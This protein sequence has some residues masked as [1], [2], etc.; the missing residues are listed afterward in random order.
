MSTARALKML[1]RFGSL[2]VL[3]AV[4]GLLLGACGGGGRRKRAARVDP[5]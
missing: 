5:A 3:G 2:F 1:F 4:A